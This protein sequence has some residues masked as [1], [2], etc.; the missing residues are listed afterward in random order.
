MITPPDLIMPELIMPELIMADRPTPHIKQRIK[1]R[2]MPVGQPV[3]SWFPPKW[4][5]NGSVREPIP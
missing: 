1:Q 5:I 4:G 2:F 3:R